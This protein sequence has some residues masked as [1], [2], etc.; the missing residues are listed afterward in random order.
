MTIKCSR[1]C[2]G[3]CLLVVVQ[4][5]ILRGEVQGEMTPPS[6]LEMNFEGKRLGLCDTNQTEPLCLTVLLRRR[7]Q[8]GGTIV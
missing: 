8:G 4:D 6:T 5:G 1:R 2:A 3:Q 7:S